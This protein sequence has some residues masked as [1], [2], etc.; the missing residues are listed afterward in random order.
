MEA[1]L[2]CKYEVAL[3]ESE[4]VKYVGHVTAVR[5]LLI[6][7]RG[8]H[9]VVG[10]L[11]RIVLRRQGRPLIAE[12]VGLAGS[13]VKLMSYTDTHGVEV[14]CAVVAEGA[15]LS[16]P[17]GDALLGRVLNAFGK[18]IDGKGEIYAP[19]R[20]EVLRASSNPMERLP[21]TRQMVTGVRVLDSLLAVGCG[22][23]LGIFSGSGVGKSTLMGM[24]ARNTDADVSV[25]ALIGER[26]REVMD[27]VAH[28]LGP[29]GLKRSVIVSA[30]SDESPLARVRGAYTATAIAEYFRDQGKQVLL[31]F[32]S[33]TRFAKAQREIGLASGEL[34]ATRGYTPGVFE[35]LPKLLERAGSFSMGS[36]TAFYT[37]L[38]DGDDLDEPIS[39][40]VR[41]IV[42][43]HIVLSRALAQRNH[44]PAIDV[45]QSVS[46]LAHRVLGADMKEAVRIVRR[47]LAVYA[48]VEDL[49]RVGA[50][51]Q[52]S[53]AELDRA[54]AM[55]AELER[56]L[57]QGA[58]ERVRFQDT[59]TSLSMLTG[60]SIAQPP[61]GV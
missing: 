40:A 57:T 45:L 41:G 6:E 11:C 25:I 30:T 17:V 12:V 29:E 31:L 9:A 52:G 49:V 61:S 2:L 28:D 38:V 47:A 8:P 7:S 44:Y 19:L 16:V 18:A 53:D 39:D 22:Q 3:R 4:P 54:I 43:G 27:F 60:L 32:D 15:A 59:V 23:R 50:Y 26:G 10:E 13:T 5:G 55:R 37:V 1:D 20:S 56:F 51:Q 14:G 46:R 58:Q 42:D 21:I 24:I 33:L 48:E 36:V 34:P 35:T